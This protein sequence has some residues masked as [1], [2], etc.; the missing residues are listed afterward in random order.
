MGFD[1][2]IISILQYANKDE[3]PKGTMPCL[4]VVHMYYYY[5]YYIFSPLSRFFFRFPHMIHLPMTD[6]G[7]ADPFAF[8]KSGNEELE[9][10]KQ[11]FD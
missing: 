2:L 1:I 9:H 8:F 7:A 4:V 3:N 11:Y 5:K 10:W 6:E